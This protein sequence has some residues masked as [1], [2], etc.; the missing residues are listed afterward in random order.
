[1]NNTSL[2]DVG[3]GAL[4]LCAGL[5]V[6]ATVRALWVSA[7]ARGSLRIK[8]SALARV[9]AGPASELEVGENEGH[10]HPLKNVAMSQN[11][12]ELYDRSRNSLREMSQWPRLDARS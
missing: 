11:R 10:S 4:C 6:F 5:L 12:L 7:I 9:A 2:Q 8:I 1:M 3:V